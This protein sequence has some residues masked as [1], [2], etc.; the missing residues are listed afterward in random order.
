MAKT[1]K[2]NRTITDEQWKNLRSQGM[3][4]KEIHAAVANGSLTGQNANS[5]KYTPGGSG[6][7]N[8]NFVYGST[9]SSQ[10]G[11]QTTAQNGGRT[12]PSANQVSQSFINGDWANANNSY[13]DSGAFTNNQNLDPR[14]ASAMASMRRQGFNFD[15]RDDNG[16]LKYDL[17]QYNGIDSSTSNQ[18]LANAYLY[19]N[20]RG[21]SPEQQAQ[22]LQNIQ[23]NYDANGIG[24]D[25]FTAYN[26]AVFGDGT[27]N[28][29]LAAAQTARET[30]APQG[31]YQLSNRAQRAQ[32][33]S[34][35]DQLQA[36]LD[37]YK[38]G[39]LYNRVKAENPKAGPAQLQ[40]LVDEAYDNELRDTTSDLYRTTETIKNLGD[41][42]NNLSTA[43]DEEDTATAGASHDY[44]TAYAYDNYAQPAAD[45]AKRNPEVAR[46]M[47]IQVAVNDYG[48]S[49]QQAIDQADSFLNDMPPEL[50]MKIADYLPNE[51]Q[52]NAE[53]QR[54][55]QQYDNLMQRYAL[56]RQN[57][58]EQ[59]DRDAM[60]QVYNYQPGATL[61]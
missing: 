11:A 4:G 23:D 31:E 52:N 49:Q 48:L 7:G 43:I 9:D 39:E 51:A 27:G 3:S 19:N 17:S 58:R 20:M 53:R 33:T 36:Q 29:G 30:R 41:T 14:G 59:R 45:F 8:G 1:G 15:Q 44:Q 25:V 54:Q 57:Q 47:A 50:M 42:I 10:Q 55:R 60:N 5:Y 18:D 37:D 32:A 61:R 40:M 38:N 21:M 34:E 28:N 22:T 12:P 26:N 56:L 13:I 2:T 16:N 46:E 35:R 6:S 24:A